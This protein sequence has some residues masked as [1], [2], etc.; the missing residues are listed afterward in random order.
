MRVLTTRQARLEKPHFWYQSVWQV[1]SNGKKIHDELNIAFDE[2]ETK[3]GF[4][5]GV[6]QSFYVLD[7]NNKKLVTNR[8]LYPLI[9]ALN[10]SIW[11]AV[12]A[13]TPL[14]GAKHEVEAFTEAHSWVHQE[15]GALFQCELSLPF[16]LLDMELSYR[17]IKTA[18]KAMY[19]SAE[20]QG[21]LIS[22]V[23]IKNENGLLFTD[24]HITLSGFGLKDTALVYN[25]IR[26]WVPEIIAPAANSPY[27]N[28][29]SMRNFIF[30]EICTKPRIG[31]RISQDV[32]LENQIES[33]KDAY[34]E[35]E[36]NEKESLLTVTGEEVWDPS[37]LF[38]VEYM[39]EVM[40]NETDM[41]HIS[42]DGM[43]YVAKKMREYK[44]KP[45]QVLID[46]IS[47]II[48][49]KNFDVC[50][51]T[52]GGANSAYRIEAVIPDGM[53]CADDILF[54]LAM[55]GLSIH[56][57]NGFP[58]LPGELE[59]AL[60]TGKKIAAEVIGASVYDKPNE[61]CLA[62]WQSMTKEQKQNLVKNPL[63]LYQ[64]MLDKG[65]LN[66]DSPHNFINARR[67][68]RFGLPNGLIHQLQDFSVGQC[69]ANTYLR[70]DEPGY[71]AFDNLV[72]N[73]SWI[74]R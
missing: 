61:L 36:L 11:D 20:K 73:K 48:G 49:P 66:A 32:K 53:C 27:L 16:P 7:Y 10:R 13:E 56:E 74:K 55:V 54:N 71:Q 21:V 1:R 33:Y 9:S 15:N 12:I 41:K 31:P 8:R 29:K 3:T 38:M 50:L 2:D 30:D 14:Y 69:A 62:E 23:F 72:K 18:N 22:P 35:Q 28:S 37:T 47:S 57:N 59:T 46:K 39:N 44:L 26:S 58:E 65:A 34:R 5:I 17:L 4:Y 51:K 42:V 24:N 45:G 19:E 6:E 68:R 25:R 70:T 64:Y 60:L 43:D 52:E 63:A 67:L 40:P